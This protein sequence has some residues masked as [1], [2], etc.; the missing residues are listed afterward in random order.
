MKILLEKD[1]GLSKLY[2]ERKHWFLMDIK[3]L[4]NL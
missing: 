3:N 1:E 2:N 4:V